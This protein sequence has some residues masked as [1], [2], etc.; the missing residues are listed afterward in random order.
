[1]GINQGSKCSVKIANAPVAR[2]VAV[3]LEEK[4]ESESNDN[5]P[6]VIDLGINYL[7][8]TKPTDC[9]SIKNK[10]IKIDDCAQLF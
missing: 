4:S 10:H 1:M 7:D 5:S 2:V 8:V 3:L 6:P 9:N